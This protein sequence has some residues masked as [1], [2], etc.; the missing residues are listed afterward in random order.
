M[1]ECPAPQFQDPYP[2]R[3]VA[4]EEWWQLQPPA[5]FVNYRTACHRAFIAG[6]D[7]QRARIEALVVAGNN[8]TEYATAWKA[9]HLHKQ[10]AVTALAQAQV[11]IE[12]VERD[13]DGY[14]RA[15]GMPAV[16]WAALAA[17]RPEVLSGEQER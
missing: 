14:R 9:E 10:L 5:M 7:M 13:I 4:F 3:A 2:E 17:H 8:L 1:S 6:Y 15:L 12:A 16:D 11:R